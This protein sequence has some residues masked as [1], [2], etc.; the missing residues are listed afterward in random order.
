MY[1]LRGYPAASAGLLQAVVSRLDEFPLLKIGRNGV[2]EM[3]SFFFS[4][5]GSELLWKG[6]RGLYDVLPIRKLFAASIDF[7]D[8]VVS[9]SSVA[10]L[11]DMRLSFLLQFSHRKVVLAARSEHERCMFLAGLL[12]LR[13]LATDCVVG[14]EIWDS[15]APLLYQVQASPPQQQQLSSQSKSISKTTASAIQGQSL[16]LSAIQSTQHTPLCSTASTSRATA[17]VGSTSASSHALVKE[18]TMQKRV[19]CAAS[20]EISI[21]CRVRLLGDGSVLVLRNAAAHK[22]GDTLELARSSFFEVSSSGI[23][24]HVWMSEVVDFFLRRALAAFFWGSKQRVF[25]FILLL[26]LFLL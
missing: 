17:T 13:D 26:C 10:K 2:A 16:L 8:G 23:N 24:S 9:D 15:I 11:H 7:S 18:M 3:R 5:D 19:E 25:L 14:R 12:R 4:A 1:F 20:D 6:K 21:D 22:T